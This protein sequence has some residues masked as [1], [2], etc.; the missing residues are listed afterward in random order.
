[1]LIL[2]ALPMMAQQTEQKPSPL[3]KT[4]QLHQRIAK[5]ETIGRRI[6]LTTLKVSVLFVNPGLKTNKPVPLI[7]HFHGVPWLIQFHTAQYFSNAGLITIN[8]GAGSRAYNRP[9]EQAETFQSLIDEARRGLDLKREWS[10]ITLVGFSVGYGAVRAILRHD[11]N[12]RRVNN[13]LLLDGIHAN[14]VPEGKPLAEGGTINSADLD[15]FI[16]FARDAAAGKKSFVITHSEIFPGTYAG[17]TE[18]VDYLL[19]ILGLKRKKEQQ[20][21]ESV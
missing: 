18:C 6:D 20:L 13:V 14:Y 5:I 16:R 11:G 8:L 1:M 10:S 12:F 7:I 15:S 21:L 9:F 17:T 4:I 3:P 19:L 2:T